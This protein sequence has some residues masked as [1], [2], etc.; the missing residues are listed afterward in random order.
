MSGTFY[1]IGTP[2][3]N[4]DDIT[5]RQLDTLGAVDFICAEDTRVTLK[6]LNRFEI[7]KPL[8]SFHEHSSKADAQKIIDRL[9]AG[10]SCGIVTDAGMPCISDPGAELIS[11]CRECGIDVESVPGPTAF[12]TAFALTGVKDTKF[13]FVGFMPDKKTDKVAILRKYANLDMPL[14]FYV[15]PH[16]LAQTA[17]IMY[18]VLGDRKAYVVREL[19]KIYE[20]VTITSLANFSSEE[21]GEIVLIIEGKSMDENPLLNMTIEEHLNHYIELGMDK[22]EAV[23][24]VAQDRGITKNDVYQV[25]INIK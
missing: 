18:E 19:T 25:A 2:I 6:L 10:E 11:K 5:I 22:K 7:K 20:S 12:A 16:D 9:L 21:R 8:V 3:G 23:K 1:V 24:K 14:I 15:A 4:L 17:Q 13:T